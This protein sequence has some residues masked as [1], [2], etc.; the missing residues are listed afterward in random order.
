MN[1]P[2]LPAF[3]D[4]EAVTPLR[5]PRYAEIEAAAT[6]ARAAGVR[7][8]EEDT[9]RV[10]V[11]G[12]D[13]QVGFCTPG[14][15]L[16]VPGA[17]ADMSRAATFILRNAAR[18]T[19]LIFSLDTHTA[20][21]I[22]HP[23][24]WRDAA[25]A[26]PAPLTA[27]SAAEVRAGRWRPADP[28]HDAWALAYCEALEG[29]GRYMLTIW[30]YHTMLGALDHALVPGLFEVAHYHALLRTSPVMLETKGQHP[31]T[32]S[33]SVLEPDVKHIGS[34]VVGCFNQPLLDELLS[35]DEVIVF[36]EA[37]SHCVRATLRSMQEALE[38]R[39]P[40][41]LRRITLLTDCMSPVPAVCGPD[42][43]PLPGL[44]FPAEAAASLRAFEAA[45]MRLADASLLLG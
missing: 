13:C 17:D 12:I 9:R 23:A 5:L 19:R 18:I 30:P 4:A 42:G 34:K 26:P 27:I 29:T 28:A 2:A 36:G 44:D 40:E 41:L 1:E 35:F 39:S 14:A 21:Q 16:F 31:L 15:S 22:F 43:A 10:A 24:F 8:A 45:G 38:E 6:L 7:P 20:Y 25:G 32:E 37:S 33:Y 11:F 3:F